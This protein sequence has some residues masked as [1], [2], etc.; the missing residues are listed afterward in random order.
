M[1]FYD[2]AVVFERGR[3]VK[4]HAPAIGCSS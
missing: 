2:S 1:H 3:H 4:K